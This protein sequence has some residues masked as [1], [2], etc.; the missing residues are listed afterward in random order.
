MIYNDQLHQS[1]KYI[2]F[3][4]ANM[5]ANALTTPEPFIHPEIS[6]FHLESQTLLNIRIIPECRTINAA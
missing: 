4:F 1:H 3:T 5:F 2:V 6:N